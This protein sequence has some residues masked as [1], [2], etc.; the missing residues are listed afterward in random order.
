MSL[1]RNSEENICEYFGCLHVATEKIYE[2]A[3]KEN[4]QF[5][6]YQT[7]MIHDNQMYAISYIGG[8][9]YQY[10]FLNAR[11]IMKSLH[12]NDVIAAYAT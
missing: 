4:I 1:I 7:F 11:D 3:G 8:A 2:R 12:F 5:N 10:Y 9:E 6:C